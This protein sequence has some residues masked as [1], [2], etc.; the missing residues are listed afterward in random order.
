[1]TADFVSFR[2]QPH[3]CSEHYVSFQIDPTT[4]TWLPNVHEPLQPGVSLS[5]MSGGPCFRMVVAEDRIEL[6]GFIYEG[7][8]WDDG[9][10][11]ARQGALIST[12]G[13]IAPKPLGAKEPND[14]AHDEPAD[15]NRE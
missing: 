6:A 3:N 1:M 10:I 12:T 8:N 7:G 13:Q 4:V 15:E 11:M 5:G 14:D 9:I 2:R